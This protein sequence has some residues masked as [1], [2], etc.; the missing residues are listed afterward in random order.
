MDC[1]ISGLTEPVVDHTTVF[2]TFDVHLMKQVDDCSS[3]LDED[4]EL[5]GVTQR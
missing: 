2:V 3:R 4:A 5:H 1:V